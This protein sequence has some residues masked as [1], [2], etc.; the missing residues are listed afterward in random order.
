MSERDIRD[1][2]FDIW[3]EIMNIEHFTMDIDSY[4]LFIKDDKTIY[5]IIHCLEIIGEASKKISDEVKESFPAV[6]WKLMAGMRDKLI[7]DYFG[8]D[9]EIL[10][11]TITRR[12]PELK[13]DF[14]SLLDDYGLLAES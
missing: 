10:W 8:V 3:R 7:H 2:L 9:E 6:P 12:I 5:A 13:N 11:E 4:E 14:K 1:Y